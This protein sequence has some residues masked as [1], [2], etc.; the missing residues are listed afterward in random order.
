[1][2]H[3]PQRPGWDCCTCRDP[4]PCAPAKAQLSDEYQECPTALVVYLTDLRSI[5]RLDLVGE[6][7]ADDLDERFLAWTEPV[8]SHG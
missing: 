2:M 7:T 5:A 3:V 1:M 6:M 8:T 4:W